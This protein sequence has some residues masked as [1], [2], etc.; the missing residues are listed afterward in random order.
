MGIQEV[1]LLEDTVEAG[2]LKDSTLQEVQWCRTAE[3][4][5]PWDY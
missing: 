4:S 2:I 5:F 1:F 3:E